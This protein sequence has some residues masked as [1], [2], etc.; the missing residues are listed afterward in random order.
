MRKLS[1]TIVSVLTIAGCS[2]MLGL[3]DYDIDPAL[4]GAGG[5]RTGVGGADGIGDAGADS[6]SSGAPSIP[7]GGDPNLPAGGRPGQG[8]EPQGQGGEPQGQGG[9]PQG[10]GG[11][12]QGQGGEPQGQ[13]GGGPT[14]EVIPCDSVVCCTTKGGTPV[15]VELLSDGGFERGLASGV[16]SPWVQESTLDYEVVAVSDD[17]DLGFLSKSGDY[18][19]YLSGAQGE[20]SSI[21]SEDVE[22]PENA[23]WLTISGW[24]LFQIDVQDSLNEDFCLI[25]LWDPDLEDPQE[26]PFWWGKPGEYADGWGDTPIWKKFEASFDAAP[27]QGTLR[28]LGLR[29]ESDSYPTEPDPADPD[30]TYASSFL[31]DDVS[32]KAFTCV[33]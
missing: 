5:T 30:V 3:G 33:K 28:Y 32:L 2:Q 21:Y 22:I 7:V 9:E 13:G 18:Y 1:L 19:A 24:R 16:E 23:G 27:H 15:G 6:T 29:G 11:E 26:L 8:G 10:Q 31:F 4:D 14:G 12:P 17:P 25:A 20:R